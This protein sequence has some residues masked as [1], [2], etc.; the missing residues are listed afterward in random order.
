[1]V[2]LRKAVNDELKDKCQP[3]LDEYENVNRQL[4][5]LHSET[6]DKPDA[7]KEQQIKDLEKQLDE[8]RSKQE[9]IS[10]EFAAGHKTVSQLIDLAL[11]A[12]GLLKG[13]DLTKFIRRSVEML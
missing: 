1:I 11:L 12:N 6:K 10:S 9:S 8:I 5:T 13:A 2:D 4:D 7:E 3:L